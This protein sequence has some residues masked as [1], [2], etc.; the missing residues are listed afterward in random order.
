VDLWD[1]AT[2]EHLVAITPIVG[3]WV[4]DLAWSPD[5]EHLA[6]AK[7]TSLYGSVVIVDRSG[8]EVGRS[9][10]EGVVHI[11]SV[12]FSPDGRRL[13]TTREPFY[14][15]PTKRGVRI[16]DWE[17]D[18]EIRTIDTLTLE[19]VFDP[20]S[21]RIATIGALGG[22][23]EIWDADTGDDL[24]TLP[25]SD[26]LLY[27]VAFSEDGSQLA[28]AGADGTVRLWDPE[29]GDLRMTLGGP[30]VPIRS[31]VFSPD[32]TRLASLGYDGVVRVWALD[33][34]DLVAIANDRLTRT[35]TVEECRQFLH[36]ESCPES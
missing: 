18:E 19:A 34:D 15:D 36:V 13:A 22:V 23:A 29:T 25:Q 1:T 5:G 2:G 28:T 8:T 32:G 6:I 31:V 21:G 27:D 24:L 35:F 11:R 10:E 30:E 3:E 7:S 9:Q 4:D 16:W 33:L 14:D 12:S 20:T 17:R 26:S